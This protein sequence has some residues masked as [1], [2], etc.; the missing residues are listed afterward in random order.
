[1]VRKQCLTVNKMDKNLKE[2]ITDALS[3][4]LSEYRDSIVSLTKANKSGTEF[5]ISVDFDWDNVVRSFESKIDAAIEAAR[6]EGYDDGYSAAED[7]R[8]D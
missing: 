5:T 1:M 2:E 3:D 4:Y 6:N 8:K 7:T